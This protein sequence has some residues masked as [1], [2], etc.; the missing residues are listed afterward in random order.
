MNDTRT[1]EIGLGKEI[2]LNRSALPLTRAYHD[3]VDYNVSV[4]YKFTLGGIATASILGNFL[5]FVVIC[6]LRSLTSKTYNM[7]L[8][9]LTITDLLTGESWLPIKSRTS[10][11]PF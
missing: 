3:K 5:L 9:N 4:A 2:F 10:F 11:D 8:L 6:Q 7:L 1:G